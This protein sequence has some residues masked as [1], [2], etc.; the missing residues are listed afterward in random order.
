MADELAGRILSLHTY[1]LKILNHCCKKSLLQMG[2][3]EKRGGIVSHRQSTPYSVVFPSCVQQVN[4]FSQLTLPLQNRWCHHYT[5]N[6]FCL[7]PSDLWTHW[8][9]PLFCTQ[10]PLDK[11]E[12][13]L[14]P[15]GRLECELPFF[16]QPVL[17]CWK[18]TQV[19]K[20]WGRVGIQSH[21]WF[22]ATLK[23]HGKW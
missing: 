6:T 9:S 21:K 3:E 14:Q 15:Q 23:V 22:Q 10:Q 7:L 1:S 12:L 4:L 17:L 13:W 18:I 20:V 8:D 2:W 5:F 11:A 16:I 19:G